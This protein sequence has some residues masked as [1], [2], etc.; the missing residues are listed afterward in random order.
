MQALTL[1]EIIS[2]LE[3]FRADAEGT[4][5]HFH[6]DFDKKLIG[7]KAL[8]WLHEAK[9]KIIATPLIHQSSNGQV[10][11]TWQTLMRMGQANITEKQVGREFWFHAIHVA[12]QMTNQVPGRLGRKLTTPF[13]LV[14]G[15]KPDASTWFELFSVGFFPHNSDEGA[16][17]SKLQAQTLAGIVLS[18]DTQSNSILFY[19]PIN[20]QYYRPPI[21]KLDESRLPITCFPKNIQ[22]DG[23]LSCGL[24]SDPSPEPFPPGTHVSIDH[25]IMAQ[26]SK[27]P[28][29]MSLFQFLAS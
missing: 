4:P 22:F 14:H 15:I 2:C 26:L 27:T 11:G 10:E 25:N 28:Y 24:C 17:K 23:G 7:G 19:N 3:A 21:Y 9:L 16:T 12:A 6:S 29:P 18:C 1:N 13:E 5:K 20:K 8:R